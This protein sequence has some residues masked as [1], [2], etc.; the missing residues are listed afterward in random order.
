MGDTVHRDRD[1]YGD[2]AGLTAWLNL[3][4]CIVWRF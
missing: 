4:Q 3:P 2:L 1:G